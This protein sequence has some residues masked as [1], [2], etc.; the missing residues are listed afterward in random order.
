MDLSRIHLSSG[1]HTDW[2]ILQLEVQYM[3]VVNLRNIGCNFRWLLVDWSRNLS[4]IKFNPRHQR[5]TKMKINIWR[6]IVILWMTWAFSYMYLEHACSLWLGNAVFNYTQCSSRL[7]SPS[8]SYSCIS[9]H[10][11]RTIRLWHSFSIHFDLLLKLYDWQLLM[12]AVY[13]SYFFCLNSEVQDKFVSR[14]RS[15]TN[16]VFLV[17]HLVKWILGCTLGSLCHLRTANTPW[18]IDILMHTQS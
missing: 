17:F 18:A 12:T 6:S 16:I 8:N 14:W 11:T 3:H 2:F 1:T 9:L 10:A 5:S 13:L 15:F 4:S 7:I